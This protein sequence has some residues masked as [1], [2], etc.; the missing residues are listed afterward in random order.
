MHDVNEDEIEERDIPSQEKHGDENDESRIG[1]LLVATKTALLHV[2]RPG[3][4]L[5]LDLHFAEK[6]LG[7]GDHFL[8]RLTTRQE[9]LEPPTDGFGDRNSTN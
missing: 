2:P 4:F 3:S 8:S 7:F 6:V 5:Q 9:G 1:Q